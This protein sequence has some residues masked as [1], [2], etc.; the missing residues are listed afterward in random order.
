MSKIRRIEIT[1][2][3]QPVNHNA[4]TGDWIEVD[5]MTWVVEDTFPTYVRLRHYDEQ[6][7]LAADYECYD[8]AELMRKDAVFCEP[9]TSALLKARQIGYAR[10]K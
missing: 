2:I 10:T 9:P 7:G 5:G 6:E 1:L 8:Y 4:M 3:G